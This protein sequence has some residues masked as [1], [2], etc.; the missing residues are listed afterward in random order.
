MNETIH[1]LSCSIEAM[2]IE[3]ESFPS[4]QYVEIFTLQNQILELM[5]LGVDDTEVLHR[6][7][8]LEEKLVPGSVASI[9]I[10]D[11]STGLMNVLEAPSIP[12]HG[13]K[14]L[15]GLRPGPGGGSCGN[16]LYTKQAQFVT[17]IENDARWDE[18]RPVAKAFGLGACWSMPVRSEGNTIIGTFAL[19]SFEKRVPTAFHKS[20]LEIGAFIVGILLKRREHST[21]IQEHKERIRILGTAFEK[22]REGIMISNECNQIIEVNQA[23]MDAFGYTY[24]EV[25]GK[26]PKILAS[27]RHNHLYYEQMW[28]AINDEGYWNGEIW[29]RHKDGHEIVQWMSISVIHDAQTK[30]KNYLAL[31]LD[32][33]QLKASEEKLSYMAFHD[34]LTGLAN[35][36]KLFERI[37]QFIKRSRRTQAIGALLYLDLDRFK[38]I[39]DSLGHTVG[40]QML[41]EV[42]DRL[43]SRIR[44]HDLIAR[45]GGDEFVLWL[46]DLQNISEA[47][48]VAEKFLSIFNEPFEI[49]SHEYQLQGSIGIALYP[50]DARERDSLL[51]NADAAMYRAKED[52]KRRIAFYRAQMTQ[53]A[54]TSLRLETELYQALKN[55]DFELY[56]QPKIDANSGE[57]RGAE[58]LIRWNHPTRGLVLPGE[59]IPFAEQTALISQLGEYVLERAFEQLRIW[60]QRSNVEMSMSVNISGRQLNDDDI[61]SLLRIIGINIDL[62]PFIVIELTETFLM[63]HAH[64]A[65]G[66]LE[67]LK[68]SG[69]KLS[70]DDFGTGY[71]SLG[72]LKRFKVDELKID[73]LLINDIEI[74]VNDRVISSAV[75]AMAHTLGLSV[76]AEGVETQAQIEILRESGCD[77]FQGFYFDCPLDAE[78]FY[79]RYLEGKE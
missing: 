14:M 56:Y 31:T 5:A 60:Q 65:V 68:N 7:C 67:R 40:D 10:L 47:E 26:N 34:P 58:A 16:V 4:S 17:D 32:I 50:Q 70:I 48:I 30:A 37:D 44:S 21:Q 42:A 55:R 15:N 3:S 54:K 78:T 12:Q 57:M 45:V 52:P 71:S 76:V 49:N 74:D 28:K 73:R 59:F 53:Q 38:N 69:V 9:M 43:S 19:S 23:F 35:R 77:L 79:K 41:V 20:L 11:E 46:E 22:A 64:S 2:S 62:A 24:E 39:N 66:M 18:L 6:L 75:I 63:H 29:N 27:G 33:S 8:E 51:K 1:P 61:N 36:T 13:I 72:Y 25:I